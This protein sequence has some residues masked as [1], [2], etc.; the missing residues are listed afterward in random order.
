MISYENLVKNINILL[1]DDDEDYLLIT[2]S[3]LKQKGYNVDK[4]S[5]GK[6][7]LEKLMTGN[8]Q[9]ALLDYFM[10]G[11]NG[12][13]VTEKIREYNKEL[14]IILQTGFSGQKPPIEMLKKLDIQ[15]YYDKTEGIDKLN[16]QLISAVRI[17]KQQTQIALANYRKNTIGN[18]MES[19]AQ[20][21]RSNLLT[22]GAGLEITNLMVQRSSGDISKAEIEKINQYYNTN[23]TSLEEIDK[24][25]TSIIM[26]SQDNSST[27]LKDKDIIDIINMII[28]DY[29]NKRDIEFV[30]R[31]SLKSESY[32]S[33]RIND[34]IFIICEILRNIADE[35]DVSDKISFTLTEDEKHWYFDIES[36]N[37]NKISKSSFSLIS[38]VVVSI[39]GN[40]ITSEN[41]KVSITLSKSPQS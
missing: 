38:N 9:I 2:Y 3:F 25:L 39:D 11:L 5:N 31:T 18:L 29:M 33:G 41:D 35:S 8:Y 24:V 12:E 40:K 14:I 20:K 26:Q 32:F 36:K 37:I 28:S 7:A 16:L 21:I 10:P 19:I 15:N 34:I 23:K 17:F 6:D 4:V 30:A 27:I 13:E 22:I 1:A